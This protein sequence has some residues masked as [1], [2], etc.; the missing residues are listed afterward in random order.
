M[1]HRPAVDVFQT[2]ELSV[3]MRKA[4][5]V[6]EVH[7]LPA[8]RFE[9]GQIGAVR[10]AL[11][12]F[13]GERVGQGIRRGCCERPDQSPVLRARLEHDHRPAISTPFEIQGNLEILRPRM[14]GQEGTRA[15]QARLFGIGEEE[16]DIVEER[17]ARRESARS[18]QQSRDADRI[19]VRARSGRDRIVMRQKQHGA[20]SAAP[21]L[22]RDDVLDCPSDK[23]GRCPRVH[24][25]RF[26]DFGFEPKSAEFLENV[27]ARRGVI[28]RSDGA[29]RA[30]DR[31]HVPER[32]FGRELVRRSRGRN[33]GWRMLQ[34]NRQE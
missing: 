8:R 21:F 16:D 5:D 6:G 11:V 17:V 27:I 13:V 10:Q 15:E 24:S 4:A 29:R 19:V 2:V 20:P 31:R 22:A 26:L 33:G 23:Q 25:R 14:L 3:I 12:N 18:F 1:L 30:R 28:G 7:P 32:A 9:N 34:P